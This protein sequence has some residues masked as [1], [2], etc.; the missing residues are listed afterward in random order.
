L[1]SYDEI[2]GELGNLHKISTARAVGR[3]TREVRPRGG[4]KKKPGKKK[5]VVVTT[6]IGS[7]QTRR[8]FKSLFTAV[9]KN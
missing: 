9:R 6:I 4:C 3:D 8:K 1:S 5:R 7:V 2:A